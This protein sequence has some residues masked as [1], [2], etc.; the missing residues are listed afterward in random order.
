MTAAGLLAESGLPSKEGRALLAHCLGVPRERLLAWPDMIVAEPVAAAFRAAAARRAAGEP[1]AYL[2]GEKEFYGRLYA[3]TPDVLVPR[4]ETEQLVELALERMA[5][6]SRPRVLDL[7][8][9]SGCIAVTLA[10]EHPGARVTA[11]DVSPAALELARRNADRLGAAGIDFRP[12]TWYDALP[13]GERYDLIVSNP[14]YVAAGDPHLAA[15]RFEPA[16]ALT[17]GGDGLAC[18]RAVVDGAAARVT[19]GGWLLVEHGYDQGDAVRTL[20]AAAGWQ[21]TTRTDAAGQPRV[22]LGQAVRLLPAD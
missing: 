18:L 9:G 20:F 6:L 12:G 19:A 16:G 1:L 2:L 11:V 8:T 7:G 4:P 3:V 21:G 17:D 15:L 10:L 5:G 14:P 13:A 22:T